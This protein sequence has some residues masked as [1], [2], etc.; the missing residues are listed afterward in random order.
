MIKIK[1]YTLS[2]QN[3]SAKTRMP[4]GAIIRDVVSTGTTLSVMAEVDESNVTG[5]THFKVFGNNEPL[6][7]HEL[8]RFY[9]KSLYHMGEWVH[10][11]EASLAESVPE[12]PKKVKLETGKVYSD[13]RGWVF[14]SGPTGDVVNYV[15]GVDGTARYY[16]SESECYTLLAKSLAKYIVDQV[17]KAVDFI[18]TD[19]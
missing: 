14:V 7:A 10:I 6:D 2:V 12:E 13:D 15:I 4:Y 8:D 9:V 16:F 5:W 1:Q 18:L 19:Q 3:G 11:F 17:N